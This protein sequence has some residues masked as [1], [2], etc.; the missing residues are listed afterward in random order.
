MSNATFSFNLKNLPFN[1][2]TLARTVN[3]LISQMFPKNF[4][5]CFLLFPDE[6]IELKVMIHDMEYMNGEEDEEEPDKQGNNS[7]PGG[8]AGNHSATC[9]VC[10]LPTHKTRI[11]YGGVS[12]YSCRAFFR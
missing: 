4:H 7:A 10:K 1:F 12:C 5:N 2:C 3:L 6:V 9:S 11:H 8:G